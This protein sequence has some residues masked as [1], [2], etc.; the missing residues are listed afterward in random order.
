MV[1]PKEMS[2]LVGGRR[3]K[4]EG[5]GL[6]VG[7]HGPEEKI[8]EENVGFDDRAREGVEDP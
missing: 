6:T 4:I 5:T 7:V 2:D 3:Y 1:Q 8:A